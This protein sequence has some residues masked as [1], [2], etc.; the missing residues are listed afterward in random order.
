MSAF[1]FASGGFDMENSSVGHH[2]TADA[3]AMIGPAVLL[4]AIQKLVGFLR[5]DDGLCGHGVDY[6][7]LWRDT[8]QLFQIISGCFPPVTGAVL[9]SGHLQ[10]G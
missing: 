1:W 5:N 7:R 3:L 6:L 8:Q 4:D 2:R 9:A 10:F